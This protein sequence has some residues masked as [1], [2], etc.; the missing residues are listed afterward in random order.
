MS[1]K[2][3]SDVHTANDFFTQHYKEAQKKLSEMIKSTK[4]EVIIEVGCGTGEPLAKL[5]ELNDQVKYGIG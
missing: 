1:K 2:Q 3:W 4:A 5:L